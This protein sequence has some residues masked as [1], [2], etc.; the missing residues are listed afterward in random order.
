MH[1]WLVGYNGHTIYWVYIESHNK[2]IKV[3]NLQVFEDNKAKT[4]TNLLNHKDT[5]TI[6]GFLLVDDNEFYNLE[7]Q[8]TY[9][10]QAETLMAPTF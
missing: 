9:T 10:Y 1:R 5:P 8:S 2:L 7:N 4:S 6:Q 3:K